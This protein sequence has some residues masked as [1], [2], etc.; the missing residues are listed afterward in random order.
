MEQEYRVSTGIQVAHAA[1]MNASRA[2]ALEKEQRTDVLEAP[3][4]PKIRTC[5]IFRESL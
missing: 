1:E 5:E 2:A 4:A 3:A